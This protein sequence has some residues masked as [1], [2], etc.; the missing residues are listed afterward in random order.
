MSDLQAGMS[1][2][3]EAW[4]SFHIFVQEAIQRMGGESPGY[5]ANLHLMLICSRASGGTHPGVA[6]RAQPT[7]ITAGY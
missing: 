7:A 1:E 2:V 6:G 3:R 5:E 4:E